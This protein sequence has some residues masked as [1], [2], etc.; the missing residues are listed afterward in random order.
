MRRALVAGLGVLVIGVALAG[1]DTPFQLAS[2]LKF[3]F[4]DVAFLPSRLTIYNQH[5]DAARATYT[6]CK[7]DQEKDILRALA[8]NAAYLH[9]YPLSTFSDDTLMHNVRLDTVRGNFRHGLE[10]VQYLLEAYPD[11]DLADDAAWQLAT[12][13]RRDKDHASAI[14]VLTMLINRWPDSTYADDALFALAMEH[15]ALDDPEG[16][17]AAFDALSKRY[18]ASDYAS[19]ALCKVANRFMEVQNYEAAIEVSREVIARYPCSD[20]VDNCKFRIAEAL[21][22]M[23]DLPAAL[24]AYADLIEGMPGSSLSNRAMREANTII[25]TLRRRNQ[26]VPIAPYDAEV[27]DPGKEAQD[28]WEYANHLENYHRFADAIAAYQD[29][30]ARFPGSDWYDDAMYHIGLCFQ[31][32]D[33]L[34]QEVDKAKGPEDLLRLQDQWQD[35]TGNYAGR[36][37]PGGYRSIPDAVSAFAAVANDFIGSPLR[38]DAVYQISRT[39]VDYGER[40]QKVTPDEAYA[41]EQLILNFPGSEY[42]FEA[43]SRLTRF[44]ATP[45]HWEDARE[46]YPPLAAAFPDIFPRGLEQNKEAFYEFTKLLAQRPQFA[47]FEEHEHHI[48]YRFTLSDLAPFSHYYQA[49]MAMEDGLW[50]VAARLLRPL[51][52]MPTHD[53]HGPALWLLGNCYARMGKT[54]AARGAWEALAEMHPDEG[55]ADDAQ[56]ALASLGQPQDL[57]PISGN[58]PLPPENMDAVALSHVAVY[59]PWTRSA[60]MRAY[61]LPNVWNQAQAI[62]EDWTGVEPPHKPVFY[63]AIS[64]G[65]RAGDPIRL[66]TCK[67]K[68]PPDWSAG[69]AELAQTQLQIACG[70][71]VAKLEPVVLGLA[72]FTATSLQYDLVT[73]TRDAIGSA[74]AVALPQEDVLRAREDAVKAFDEFVRE[75]SD[76]EQL[77]P[78]VVCGMLFKLLDVQGLSKDRLIDREPYRPLFSEL[79]RA[80]GKMPPAR[81]FVVALD[82]AF[83]GQARQ[84]LQRWRLPLANQMTS[85]L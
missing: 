24:E 3:S 56:F 40:R 49:C 71:K 48:P 21:R 70:E 38:D 5:D 28:L 75:G 9:R 44:L 35:A 7:P 34:L 50:A 83:G 8:A 84:H 16:A 57:P 53:L 66:C 15:Q 13:Y 43:L 29:F 63:L 39:F 65:S 23:G 12:Y 6:C 59:C 54:D 78:E 11:S 32:M 22:H 37:T 47:W 61:N 85:N 27:W 73:E 36:P 45:K 76:V 10:S 68:D 60:E 55:L 26:P 1:Q 74:A 80:E 30:M 31:K 2:T 62:L 69:F 64:G 18:P 46:L 25:R 17:F 51:S 52:Q 41:L 81:A 4:E 72:E 67:I 20:C 33:I 42:E 58:F 82:K 14:E 77:T 79:K 19:T